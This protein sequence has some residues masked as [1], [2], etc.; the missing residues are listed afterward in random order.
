MDQL[1]VDVTRRAWRLQ[2]LQHG[3]SVTP[4][5]LLRCCSIAALLQPVPALALLVLRPFI[6]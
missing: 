5:P 4:A 1:S 3:C 6:Y 2:L